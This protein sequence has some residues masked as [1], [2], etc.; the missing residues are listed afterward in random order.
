M[1]RGT[2]VTRRRWL[3]GA[4]AFAVTG[5]AGA[6]SGSAV[7]A[8]R[9]PVGSRFRVTNKCQP[10]ILVLELCPAF[11]STPE[12]GGNPTLGTTMTSVYTGSPITVR[13]AAGTVIFAGFVPT[14][15]RVIVGTVATNAPYGVTVGAV[16]QSVPFPG[17]GVDFVEMAGFTQTIHVACEANAA[18]GL[19]RVSV[20]RLAP[21]LGVIRGGRVLQS[22][23]MTSFF[24][25]TVQLWLAPNP[26]LPG[27]FLV[28]ETTISATG[29]FEFQGVDPC[30]VYQLRHSATQVNGVLAGAPLTTIGTPG[31]TQRYFVDGTTGAICD[32]LPDPP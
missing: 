13:D 17:G 10:A 30:F 4:A 28:G 24:T 9:L 31:V 12:Q 11:P 29:T 15:G 32:V 19:T 26:D 25:G 14:T 27:G 2:G 5:L 6:G 20:V 8:R 1:P 21:P 18:G 3:A 7:P 23:A 22:C 16:L